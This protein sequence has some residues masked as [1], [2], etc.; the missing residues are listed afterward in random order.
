MS[1]HHYSTFVGFI[2]HPNL[3]PFYQ[4]NGSISIAKLNEIEG[5]LANGVPDL[6][7]DA[8]VHLLKYLKVR[9]V[10][11]YEAAYDGFFYKLNKEGGVECLRQIEPI[12]PN[13]VD[14]ASSK[15]SWPVRL[16]PK[17]LDLQGLEEP[18]KLEAQL[19]VYLADAELAK[20]RLD[21]IIDTVVESSGGCYAKKVGVKTRE[22]TARKATAS[23]GGNLRKVV[24]MARVAVVCDTAQH[25]E[26]V[27]RGIISHLQVR[28][29][30]QEHTRHTRTA[31]QCARMQYLAS[32]LVLCIFLA[33]PKCVKNYKTHVIYTSF[34]VFPGDTDMICKSCFY[35][36]NRAAILFIF[37]SVLRLFVAE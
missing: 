31:P 19:D 33:C 21:E 29:T 3:L 25:L 6:E 24:D 30:L 4:M 17:V 8:K 15:E 32:Y 7:R 10:K 26:Q 16:Q 28:G 14:L 5:E 27:Y 1:W 22:S 12:P 13:N 20:Q 36:A 2:R 11:E 18:A 23:Y 9:T 34:Q 35:A 37:V